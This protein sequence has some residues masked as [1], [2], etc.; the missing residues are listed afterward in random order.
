MHTF[1]KQQFL[2][3]LNYL[4]SYCGYVNKLHRFY[5]KNQAIT[6]K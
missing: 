5:I 6:H 4:L 3:S 2:L 1:G